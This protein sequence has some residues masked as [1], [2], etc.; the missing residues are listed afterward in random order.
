MSLDIVLMFV[1]LTMIVCGLVLLFVSRG[2]RKAGYFF[3]IVGIIIL[4]I[5]LI[6]FPYLRDHTFTRYQTVE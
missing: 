6:R 5:C 1:S 4:V 2:K 3:M